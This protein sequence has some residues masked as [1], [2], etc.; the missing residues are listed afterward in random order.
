M[1]CRRYALKISMEILALTICFGEFDI[2]SV[3]IN[4]SWSEVPHGLRSSPK[5]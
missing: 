1:L 3:S 2:G 5:E 4:F